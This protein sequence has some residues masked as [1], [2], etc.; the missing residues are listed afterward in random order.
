MTKLL[1]VLKINLPSDLNAAFSDT[2]LDSAEKDKTHD[3]LCLNVSSKT[4]IPYDRVTDLKKRIR[5]QKLNGRFNVDINIKYDEFNKSNNIDDYEDIKNNILEEFRLTNKIYYNLYKNS[6]VQINGDI[7]T[8]SFYD[9]PVL[10]KIKLEVIDYIKNVYLNRF[11]K[12]ITVKIGEP[13]KFEE[14]ISENN[15]NSGFDNKKQDNT[16]NNNESEIVDNKENEELNNNLDSSENKNIKNLENKDIDDKKLIL[17]TFKNRTFNLHKTIIYGLKDKRKFNLINVSDIHNSMSNIEIRGEIIGNE[18]KTIKT[19]DNKEKLLCTLALKC[20]DD[21]IN[22][23]IWDD[24]KSIDI[25]TKQLKVGLIVAC[26]G[27]IQYS[28][29]AKE[30]RVSRVNCIEVLGEDKVIRIET[31]PVE[32]S[33]NVFVTNRVDAEPI[34]RVELHLHTKLSTNDGISSV[35]GCIEAAHKFGMSAMAITDHGTVFGLS[36]AYK[37]IENK[38]IKGLKLINGVEGYLVNDNSKSIF[39]INGNEIDKELNINGTFIIYN[40]VTTGVNA[41]YDEVLKMEAIKVKERNIIDKFVRVIKIHKKVNM[42]FLYENNISSEELNKSSDKET[43]FN[44]FIDFINKDN[45]NPILLSYNIEPKFLFIKNILSNSDNKDKYIFVDLLP[46]MM[47]SIKELTSFTYKDICKILK[48]NEKTIDKVI[49]N[50]NDLSKNIYMNYYLFDNFS[51]YIE[52]RLFINDFNDIKNKFEFNEDIIKRLKSYHIIILAK[53]DVGRV[54]LYKIVS[55]SNVSFKHKARPRIPRSLLIKYR[56]GLLLGTACVAGEFIDAIIKGA[57]DDE[58]MNIASFYDYLEIQPAL[59]NSFLM[60]E[61]ENF[62]TIEDLQNIDRKVIDIAN[63]LNKLV[64]A[65]CDAHYIDKEEKIFREMLKTGIYSKKKNRD[66]DNNIKESAKQD[67]EGSH[68]EE[69]YFRTTKEMIDEFEFLGTEKA[70]E[71]VVK[72]TNLISDM[73][74]YV[75]PVRPDKCPPIIDGADEELKDVTYK[76]LIRIY[77]DN[78]HPEVLKRYNDELKVIIDNNYSVLYISAKKCIDY[79]KDNGYPVGSRGSV[80]SSIIAFLLG[81][82]EINPLPAHYVCPN[83]HYTEF[84]EK[85]VSITGFDLEDKLCPHCKTPL[86]KDGVNCPFETFLGVVGGKPKEPDIDLNFSGE[87]QPKV[88]EYT[89]VIFGNENSYRAG[90]VLTVKRTTAYKYVKDYENEHGLHFS[91]AYESYSADKIMG[92]KSSNGQH[93]GGAVIV[94]NGEHIE[95]FTPLDLTETKD[96]KIITT[97]FD[98]HKIDENLLKLDLLGHN[99]PTLIKKLCDLTNIKLEDIP[100]YKKEIL[101]LFRNTKSLGINPNDIGGTKFGLLTIPEFGTD[102]CMNTCEKCKP[103][104][105]ADVIRISGLSHGEGVW[106][107]NAEELIKNNI[108]RIDEAICCRD[109]IMVYLES[110]NMEKKLAFDIMELVRKG[111]HLTEEHEEKM[112]SLGI[113][114][115]YIDSCNKIAYMFPKA[116]A[117]A[118]VTHALRLGYFKIY[119]PLEY[120]TVYFSVKSDGFDMR[121]VYLDIKEIREYI[122]ILKSKLDTLKNKKGFNNNFDDEE[123]GANSDYNSNEQILDFYNVIKSMTSKN[124]IED[125]LY[126]LRVVEEMKARKIEFCPIDL[127]KAKGNEFIIENGKIM[128]SFYT[129]QGI[130]PEVAN[131]LD[132]EGKIAPFSSINDMKKRTKINEK[133]INMLKQFG[134][135]DVHMKNNDNMSMFDIL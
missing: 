115:W 28:D 91:K 26:Y 84:D 14:H 76:N 109:D 51:K 52:E 105:I 110:C 15:K 106:Q 46:L 43:V 35:E 77:G 81:V 85:A 98:Y 54:N 50:N 19:K 124:I 39:D 33:Y 1:D 45:E 121:M 13:I 132:I 61:N 127:Y 66:K 131:K 82:S 47:V 60:N 89:K 134:I 59:N 11:D 41:K 7:F 18:I 114:D 4:L 25:A 102:N 62:K 90:T 31:K 70:Y 93:A 30:Y 64:V 65:T 108:C 101:E 69:L 49:L 80:G 125:T 20:D 117:A 87:F 118:Y 96:D 83:C 75:D 29:F 38:K 34:K 42:D 8:F 23:E 32:D 72:N 130:G 44:E 79:S 21:F 68:L 104:T 122:N 92:N 12:N 16:I 128:P 119:H 6:N 95:T 22:V 78:P 67:M 10:D 55:E 58:L 37:Y 99:A 100:F 40:I 2:Y 135:I 88:H 53:N 94:P 103:M 48:V 17:S 86:N 57:S 112:R 123:D 71:V 63:K 56:E 74:E 97:L 107:G 126:A 120:Y 36:D 3:A 111:K 27:S 73:I 24:I 116:H 9:N 133:S 113:P 5:N 129:V